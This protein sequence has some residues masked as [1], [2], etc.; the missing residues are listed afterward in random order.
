[1]R[2]PGDG[3]DCLEHLTIGRHHVE[4]NVWDVLGAAGILRPHDRW[5]FVPA[6]HIDPASYIPLQVGASVPVPGGPGLWSTPPPPVGS[7]FT[8]EGVVDAAVFS[9]LVRV[10][11]PRIQPGEQRV[12]GR[13]APA[14]VRTVDHREVVRFLLQAEV[15]Q[16][17][18]HIHA[19]CCLERE[20]RTDGYRAVFSGTHWYVT[21]SQN[22]DPLAFTLSISVD[23]LIEV[24]A[25]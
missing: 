6:A 3:H 4:R 1:M 24:R 20:D 10:D 18:W 19:E 15:V 13:L 5:E 17:Y 22:F 23:G 2:Q 25:G 14:A 21:N 11:V 8:P 7:G 16:T 12:I 9:P